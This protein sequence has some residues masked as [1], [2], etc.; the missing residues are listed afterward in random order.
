[1]DKDGIGVID[2]R[3]IMVSRIARASTAEDVMEYDPERLKQVLKEDAFDNVVMSFLVVLVAVIVA[4]FSYFLVE[5]AYA[6]YPLLYLA[7][8]IALIGVS[9]F[10]SGMRR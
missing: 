8:L 10:S 1:V 9:F 7:T 3:G 5:T 2:A 4:F 6:L